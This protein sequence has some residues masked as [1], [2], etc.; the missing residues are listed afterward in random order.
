[1]TQKRTG[2]SYEYPGFRQKDRNPVVCV[3]WRDIQAY[4]AWLGQ[5]TGKPYRLLSEAEWEY[6]ARAGMT[7]AYSFGNDT[8]NLCKYANAADAS[9]KMNW[10]L[11]SCN[12]GSG[13]GV[14]EV[15]RYL[16][17]GFGLHD[18]HGN[19]WEYVADCYT[20]DYRNAPADSVAITKPGCRMHITRGGSWAE[21]V[22]ALRSAYRSL[23]GTEPVYNKGFRVAR[24]LS[25]AE[26]Q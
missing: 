3:S 21:P 2:R 14:T 22:T 15:G 16:P 17:N 4:L 12:D 11:K 20:S 18:M 19:V 24:D 6:S 25:P 13:E 9:T 1:V 7:H 5:K 26:A 8:R 23:E 10:R